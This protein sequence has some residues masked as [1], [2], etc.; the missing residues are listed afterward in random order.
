MQT[1]FYMAEAD[2]GICLL[3]FRECIDEGKTIFTMADFEEPLSSMDELPAGDEGC[4]IKAPTYD[5][6]GRRVASTARGGIY[7]RDGKKFV[8]Q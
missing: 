6:M 2:N 1:R 8:G 5:M 3:G 4:R 7:I